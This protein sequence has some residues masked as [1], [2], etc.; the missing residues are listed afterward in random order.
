MYYTNTRGAVISLKIKG[1]PGTE[2]QT[3]MRFPLPKKLLDTRADGL[4]QTDGQAARLIQY[5][6]LSR[7]SRLLSLALKSKC[8]SFRF[9]E[10]CFL[11]TQTRSGA[12][13]LK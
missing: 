3:A 9:V 4:A 10:R 11:W 8:F 7:T 12:L 6:A 5:E 1:D 2:K 13:L